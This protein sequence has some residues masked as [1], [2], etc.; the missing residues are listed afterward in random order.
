MKRTSYE[1]KP[2]ER[3][4]KR[5]LPSLSDGRQRERA[6]GLIQLSVDAANL[7]QRLERSP[8]SWTAALAEDADANAGTAVLVRLAEEYRAAIYEVQAVALTRTLAELARRVVR[9]EV[10]AEAAIKNARTVRS[11]Y[12]DG[13]A[14]KRW[15]TV[16]EVDDAAKAHRSDTSED[17]RT[18]RVYT[19][20]AR[21]SVALPGTVR[22]AL[23]GELGEIIKATQ[24]L[25]KTD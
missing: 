2:R 20:L 10:G 9:G 17:V 18:L 14:E 3:A 22:V 19:V 6:L 13:K 8:K 1:R 16:A 21:G 12:R 4:I 23:R 11:A 5:R 15:T 25:A 7:V 24:A